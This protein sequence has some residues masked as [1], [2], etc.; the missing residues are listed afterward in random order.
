MKAKIGVQSNDVWS[1]LQVTILVAPSH[2]TKRKK[3]QASFYSIAIN[4]NFS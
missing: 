4:I 3:N 1:Y 2:F